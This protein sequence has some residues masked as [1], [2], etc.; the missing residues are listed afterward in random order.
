MLNFNEAK[1]LKKINIP[2]LI[3]EGKSDYK[4]PMTVAREMHKTIK[5]SKLLRA[6]IRS[7]LKIRGKRPKLVRKTGT[8]DMNT[9]GNQ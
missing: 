6:L 2:T 3:I 7:I 8:G 1:I 5:N 9:L 4:T